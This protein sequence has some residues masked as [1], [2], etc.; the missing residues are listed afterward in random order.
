M[1]LLRFTAGS[2]RYA[3]AVSRVVEVLPKLEL[4]PIPH[5][6][7]VLAG[8]LSYRG[9][10]VPVI[11]LGLLLGTAP[12]QNLLSSRMILVDDAP[13]NRNQENLTSAQPEDHSQA[14]RSQT[15]ALLGLIAENVNDLTYV[16]PEQISPVPVQVP[17]A[18]YL[19][20]IVKMD[21]EIIPLIAVE[22]VRNYLVCGAFFSQSAVL[23]PL[24]NHPESVDP[25]HED[26]ACTT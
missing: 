12:C 2:S 1:L 10:V 3:I 13:G 17:N 15:P 24:T 8:L 23:D 11:D 25:Y 20:V 9:K 22:K 26:Q 4:R 18:P 5:A 7:P 16:E 21:R 19:D 14:A 6:P